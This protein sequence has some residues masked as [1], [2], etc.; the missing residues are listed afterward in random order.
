MHIIFYCISFHDPRN[1][2]QLKDPR[3]ELGISL[4]S[5]LNFIK[6]W[7]G[8]M[9]M[10]LWLAL[11]LMCNIPNFQ[12]GM[13]YIGHSCISYFIAFSFAILEVLSNSRTRGESWEFRYFHI[14]VFLKFWKEDHLVLII[15]LSEY[16]Q[17]ENKREG[18]KWLLQN[19]EILEEKY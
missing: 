11:V 3:R 4:F 19:K 13:L 16:F 2:K 5:Y 15:F 12:F 14:W 6:Y 7:N 17:H 8:T 10:L 18:I 9:K 1:P